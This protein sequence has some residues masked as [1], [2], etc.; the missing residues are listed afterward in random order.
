MTLNEIIQA[1][2]D[3]LGESGGGLWK[4]ESIIRWV[5]LALNR[6]A[7]EALSVEAEV[8]TSVIGG[9]QE[10]DLPIDFGELQN[11]RYAEQEVFGLV[12][13]VYV[14]KQSILSAYGIL[15][16]IGTPYACY[17][18]GN[19]IG[20]YPVPDKKPVFECKF[21]EVCVDFADVMTETGAYQYKF[22]IQITGETSQPS[23][24]Y[25]PSAPVPPGS[26]T[27]PAGTGTVAVDPCRVY[28]GQVGVYLRRIGLPYP[29]HIQMVLTPPESIGFPIHSKPLPA[30]DITSR[31]EWQ[32]F[33]FTLSP[34]ELNEVLTQWTMTIRGDADY[35]EANA[36]TQEGIGVQLGVDENNGAWFDLHRHQLNLHIDYYRNTCRPIADP[37]VQLKLPFYPEARHHPT[38]VKMTLDYALRQGQYDIPA[39][40]DYR[41]SAKTEIDYARAQVSLLTRGDILRVPRDVR[42][43][44][45]EGPYVLYEDGRFIGRAW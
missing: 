6:H 41:A 39:A 15:D 34:M 16:I 18:Y 11:V 30:I 12:P 9:V 4:T 28:V 43:S 7:T 44:Q 24:T 19:K 38:L 20:L 31:P 29:G 5:H 35:I 3:E 13:L 21:T 14:D 45:S 40:N 33:D 25:Q 8:Q 26:T 23:G 36:A 22:T 17:T 32:Y 1:V 37:D 10:Y 42:L 2:R 27:S